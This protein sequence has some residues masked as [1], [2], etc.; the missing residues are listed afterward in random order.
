MHHAERVRLAE[1]AEHVAQHPADARKGQR[2]LLGQDVGEVLARQILHDQVED[3]VLGAPEIDDRDAVR[4]VEAAGR[5]GL[6][7]EAG[8]RLIVREQVRVD[9]L[10]RHR[11]A[12]HVLLGAVDTTHAPHTDHFLQEIGAAD[13]PPDERVG[14]RFP[15]ARPAVGAE[16]V[17][18]V[19]RRPALRTEVHAGESTP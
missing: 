4:V 7:V 5:P 12:E 3:A 13:R 1:G 14:A 19:V 2:A 9:D 6:V 15:Q 11:A 17:L 8:D 10:D 18:V 16:A